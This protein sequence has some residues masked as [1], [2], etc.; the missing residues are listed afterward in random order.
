[1]E[2]VGPDG[3]C[4]GLVLAVAVGVCRV[5]KSGYLLLQPAGPHQTGGGDPVRARLRGCPFTGPAL[6]PGSCCLFRSSLGDGQVK[7]GGRS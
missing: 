6:A 2:S 1:M 5:G 4:P 3:L 7:S